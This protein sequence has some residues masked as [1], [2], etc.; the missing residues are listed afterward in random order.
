MSASSAVLRRSAV[1]ALA[2]GSLTLTACA[3]PVGPDSAPSASES[4]SPT[5]TASGGPPADEHRESPD[6][7]STAPPKST[8]NPDAGEDVGLG[9]DDVITLQQMYDFN[10][11]VSALG[12]FSPVADTP[13]AKVAS[14]NGL[15]CRWSNNTSGRTIDVSIAKLAPQTLDDLAAEADAAGESVTT[16]GE[17]GFFS[18]TSGLGT[19]QIFTSTYWIVIS[20]KDFS[21]S[22][23]AEQLAQFVLGNLP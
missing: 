10:P 15:T 8:K 5:P 16:Y 13:A 14:Y 6:D 11:N 21:D 1:I 19:A 20:S 7:T 4:S 23:G 18:H 2:L 22:R 9:C 3:P 17:K 12:E